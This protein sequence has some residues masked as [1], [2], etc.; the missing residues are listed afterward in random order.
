MKSIIV[1]SW[2]LF[3][4]IRSYAHDPGEI[5]EKLMLAFRKTFPNA[6]KV[7]WQ[8]TRETFIISFLDEG[9]NTDITYSKEGTFLRSVRYYDEKNLPLQLRIITKEQYPGRKIFGVTEVSTITNGSHHLRALYYIK[10]EDEKGWLTL[11]SD[12]DG[13]SRVVEAFEK[14]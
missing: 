11:E 14:N 2:M 8:E 3:G 6:E 5:D 9:I 1:A 4:F 10:L 13:N 7:N 12:A